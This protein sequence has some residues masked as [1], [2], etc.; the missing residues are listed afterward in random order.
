MSRV[1]K[2]D[3]GHGTWPIPSERAIPPM[4]EADERCRSRS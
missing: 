1:R 3:P 4:I 2:T